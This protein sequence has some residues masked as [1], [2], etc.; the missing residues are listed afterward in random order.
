M[1]QLA[2]FDL[3]VE[4]D[5]RA[6][7]L[8]THRQPPRA[9]WVP[10]AAVV[11]EVPSPQDET[12]AKLPFYAAEL[13]ERTDWPPADQSAPHSRVATLAAVSTLAT[14]PRRAAS[15]AA[16]TSAWT[17]ARRLLPGTD[18]IA[19]LGFAGC[20]A[21]IAFLTTGGVDLAPNTWVEIVLTAIAAAL[22][23]AVVLLGAPGRAWGA[24]TLLLFA[25]LAALTFASI[26]WSVQP[27]SS[28]VEANRTLSYLAAFAAA[29]ALARLAPGRWRALVGALATVATVL[30]GYALL[31]KV[32]PASLD[33]TDSLGRV[34]APFDYWN[35]TGLIAALGLPAC[36]WAGSRRERGRALRALAV[37]AL[38]ILVAVIVLSYS[39]GALLVAVVGAGCWF[40]LVPLRLRG[41]LV[42]ALGTA[43]GAALAAWALA[44]HP[45]THDHVALHSR[46][47]A[48]HAFGVVLVLVLGL[49]T[50]V[51]L[52]AAF[53]MDR[54]VPPAQVRRR[55]AAALVTLVA[56]VPVGGVVALAASSRG[57]PGEVSHI[58][59]TLTNPNGGAADTAGRL[60]EL[61]NSRPHYW[62]QGLTVGEH[63]PL[64][65]VGALGFATAHTRYTSD[66]WNVQHAHSYV[67]ETFADFG[68]IGI[69]LSLALLL[70]WGAA[71][72]RAVRAVGPSSD[73]HTTE[74]AG[75]LTLLTI[76]VVFG[77]HS[78]IDWTWFIPGTAIP[79]LVCAGWLAGRGPLAHPVGRAQRR[80]RLT[81]CPGAGA[82]V[83]AIAAIAIVAAWVIWQPLRS[84]D[85]DGAAISALLRGDTSAALADARAA[86]ASDP[87]S[88][89]P[90]FELSEIYS[91]LGDR[92]AAERELLDAV[93][94]Q[95]SNPA[96][97]QR[98]GSFELQHGQP[99]KALDALERA[100]RL[101]LA[102]VQT[103]QLLAR[104]RAASG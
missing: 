4:H 57:L 35:A 73:Q 76:V 39:R 37:P 29:M 2:E 78:L 60:V 38:A 96:T 77:V 12:Y 100:H 91:G 31:V 62:S 33:P 55:I 43:G 58:W 34:Q 79:A 67:I 15:G 21:M 17:R 104:A 52:A 80:R 41:A 72:R 27:A 87:V 3:R 97:W 103:T 6:P 75:L 24:T 90:L 19:G 101:D 26:A 83:T 13:S 81:S 61:S 50:I 48:G 5:F 47:S 102:S 32:F 82:A 74:R 46:T 44:T 36:L 94:R 45:L 1:Q 16:R 92:V 89:E 69:A 59:S 68:L 40:A 84:Y 63:S 8:G 53:A 98:L 51:G 22:A 99:R 93:S 86:A 66:V 30:A 28:W 10:T 49:L 71:T 23:V 7:H 25:G 88:V 42:L 64:A 56:L 14:A 18:V 54:F 9:T 95:P 65:G 85:A 70:S 20:L 11:V